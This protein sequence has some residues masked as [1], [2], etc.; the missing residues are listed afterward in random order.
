MKCR[1]KIF[2]INILLLLPTFISRGQPLVNTDS[3]IKVYNRTNDDRSK[4]DLAMTISASL[5]NSLPDKALVYSNEALLLAEKTKDSKLIETANHNA[6]IVNFEAGLYENSAKHFYK[7]LE[8]AREE[9]NAHEITR[10]LVNISAV[11]LATHQHD[12]VEYRLQSALEFL[13]KRYEED[14]DTII[15][16]GLAGVYNNL[17]VISV[18]SKDYN[19]AVEY[20]RKGLELIKPI[21]DNS[22]SKASLLNNLGKALIYVGNYEEAKRSLNEAL[23]IR[24]EVNDINGLAASYRNMAFYNEKQSRNVEAIENYRKSLVYALETGNSSHLERV[25]KG[26][27]NNFLLIEN[28]DSALRYHILYKEYSDLVSREEAKRE[29]AHHDLRYQFQQWQKQQEEA[30]QRKDQLY[31]F[32]GILLVLAAVIAGLLYFLSLGRLRRSLLQKSNTELVNKNLELAREQ[33]ESELE[34]KNKELATAVLHQI[35]KNEL[36][37][38]VSKRLQKIAPSFT[39]KNKKLINEI[40]RD[41]DQT[42]D[43]KVWDEFEIRFQQVH[44]EFY[45]KLH[46]SNPNLTVN[47]RRLCA[48]LRLNMTTKEISAIT[49][50]SLRSIEVA[51]TRLRKKLEIVNQDIS[52][53]EYLNSL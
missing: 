31:I 33:L 2:L 6:G 19:K 41:L 43:Q 36:V 12:S 21:K 16:K 26:L 23:I 50:Q 5:A 49:G 40:V 39:D 42:K 38:D 25:Y 30:Q 44:N 7:C 37:N 8:I 17:G 11:N 4:V 20:Y 9:Q 32:V 18:E 24:E 10:A 34:I 29:I 47:E 48:F 45:Q 22:Y 52:L 1:I 13:S 35:Q 27:F 14:A 15:A 53:V 46:E 28:N 3:L 51:R